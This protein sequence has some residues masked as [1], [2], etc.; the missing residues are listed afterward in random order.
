MSS[1]QTWCFKPWFL[2]LIF[3]VILFAAYKGINLA[4]KKV[5]R[6]RGFT[7]E[8]ITLRGTLPLPKVNGSKRLDEA[9]KILNQPFFYMNKGKQFFVFKSADGRYVIKFLQQQRFDVKECLDFLPEKASSIFRHFRRQAKEKRYERMM[10]S[11]DLAFDVVPEE[12]GLVY[13]HMAPNGKLNKKLTMLDNRGNCFFISLD[14][15]QFI[16]QKRVELLKPGFVRL[17]F[18]GKDEEARAR[19]KEVFRIVVKLAKSSIHDEDG[20]IIRN[21]NIGFLDGR[22]IWLDVGKFV[23]TTGEQQATA[24]FDDLRHLRPLRKWLKTNYP[25]LVSYYDE[26]HKTACEEFAS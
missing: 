26:C 12:T 20:A 15:T 17:M 11:I 22:A 16:L 1:K 3:F 24:F 8:K 21:D 19:I 14:E 13:A 2:F 9:L 10:K 23:K 7:I 4:K 25:T 6:A 5:K 18:D